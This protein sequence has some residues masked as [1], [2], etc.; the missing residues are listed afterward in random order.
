MNGILPFTII[1]SKKCTFPLLR[2]FYILVLYLLFFMFLQT[3]TPPSSPTL[4]SGSRK[5][6]V[7]GSIG[8]MNSA[9]SRSSSSLTSGNSSHSAHSHPSTNQVAHHR[10][11]SLST[12]LNPAHRLSSVSSQ[13]SGFTSQDTLFMRP[14]TPT[15]QQQ[16]TAGMQANHEYARQVQQVFQHF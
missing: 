16:Y 4:S 6:S 10:H 13:D 15:S 11:R 8:S 1:Q 14:G 9:D 12:P 7:C 5:S 2:G 3:K